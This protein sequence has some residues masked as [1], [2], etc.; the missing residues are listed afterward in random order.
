M[1]HLGFPP[2]PRPAPHVLFETGG[3]RCE[4]VVDLMTKPNQRHLIAS[5]SLWRHKI[6]PLN[7]VRGGA[8]GVFASFSISAHPFQQHRPVAQS[9]GSVH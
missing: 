2:Y 6:S 3:W 8:V 4:G 5:S 9:E 7:T 1:P